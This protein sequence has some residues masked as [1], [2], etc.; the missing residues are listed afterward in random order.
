MNRS[1]LVI[2][3]LIICILLTGCRNYREINSFYIVAGIGID[4]VPNSDKYNITAELINIV[5]NKMEK[6]FESILLET[7]GDSISDAISEM[8]RISAKRLY[9]GHATSLIISEDVAREGIMPFLDLIARNEDGRLGINVYISRGKLAKEI[10]QMKSFST[11]IRSFELE[12]MIDEGKHL[13][14][15]P[16]L[17]VYEVINALSIPKIHIVLPTVVGFNNN[18]ID[19]NLLSGGAVFDPG[20]MVGFLEED[21]ILPYL[22]L[23]DKV[24]GGI[25]N[26]SVKE[27]NPNHTV[28][29]DISNSNTKIKP[30]YGEEAIKFDI[31][32]KTDVSIIE[33]TTMTDYISLPGREEFKKIA[34]ENLKEQILSHIKKVQKEF[35]FDIFGFGNIIRERNPRLWKTIEKDW[36]TIFMEAEYNIVCDIQIINSGHILKPIKVVE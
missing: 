1:I 23:K 13:T 21:D 12:I 5:E 6:N 16:A 30:I 10:L 3:I 17:K 27:D 11:E 28:I 34:E 22:F 25:L 4:K 31:K 8:T 29:L 18:G 9:W 36:D 32:I 24:K 26:V 2:L 19:T 7:E 35:G 14:N 20:K 33:F 15:V